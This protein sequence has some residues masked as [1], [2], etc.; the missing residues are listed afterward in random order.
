MLAL[1]T[2][3]EMHA[4]WIV[5]WINKHKL[6]VKYCWGPNNFWLVLVFI[7]KVQFET[8]QQGSGYSGMTQ[9]NWA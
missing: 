6:K 5:E 4:S 1:G 8:G 2:K 9:G 3:G 7:V